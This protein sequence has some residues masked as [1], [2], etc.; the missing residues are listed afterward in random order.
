MR[1]NVFPVYRRRH[2]LNDSTLQ[3]FYFCCKYFTRRFASSQMHCNIIVC[4]MSYNSGFQYG[5]RG[6]GA[7]FDRHLRSNTSPSF[8][9]WA[10]SRCA[11][12][13]GFRMA[14]QNQRIFH[15]H[16]PVLI[17]AGRADLVVPGDTRIFLKL[18]PDSLLDL[19]RIFETS[20]FNTI[21]QFTQLIQQAVFGTAADRQRRR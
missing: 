21:A 20:G 15:R 12:T 9:T 19:R 16:G 4:L 18:A 1:I 17:R 14:L 7:I 5:I 6:I 8:A 13:T 10:I 2:R 11:A 3:V